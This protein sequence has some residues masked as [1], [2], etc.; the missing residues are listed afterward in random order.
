MSL[1][2]LRPFSKNCDLSHLQTIKD[3][4]EKWWDR[5]TPLPYKELLNNLEATECQNF[6]IQ[7]G[8]ISFPQN[9]SETDLL[10]AKNL[11][12]WKKGPFSFGETL[13]DSEWRSDLKWARLEQHLPEIQ[14]KTILDIGCANGYFLYQMAKH[15]PKL[16]L[17]IDPVLH[18]ISQF[19]FINHFAQKTNIHAEL[20]GVEHIRH[21]KNMF[22]VI[23]SMGILYHHRNPL[24]QLIEKREALSSGGTLVLETIGIAGDENISFTPKDRYA[25]MTNVWFLPTLSCLINWLERTKYVDIEIVSTKWDQANEQRVTAWSGEKS[26]QDFLDPNDHSKTIEG[27]PAPQRFLLIA[28][29][30]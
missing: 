1:E 14:G 24:Q 18:P 16:A 10:I 19:R 4:R 28:K 20:F 11:I 22:D 17:G 12:P 21:F 15:N 9:L 23:F 3:E 7:N 25:C 13:I 2:Y 6:E 29:K 8:S 30:K 27:Y 26:F 5:K